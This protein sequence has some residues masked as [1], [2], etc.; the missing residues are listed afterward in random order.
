MATEK[1]YSISASAVNAVVESA[2]KI[3]G[4][5][6]L[7]LLLEE[8]AR[9]DGTV[10]SP[11]LSAISSRNEGCANDVNDAVPEGSVIDRAAQSELIGF[12]SLRP[13]SSRHRIPPG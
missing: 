3:E 13:C 5:A 7:L 10:A 4:A 8:K 1:D 11:E 12:S 2:E 9:D 6:S